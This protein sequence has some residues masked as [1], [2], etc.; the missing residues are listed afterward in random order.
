MQGALCYAGK[1]VMDMIVVSWMYHF[2]ICYFS[3]TREKYSNAFTPHIVAF[4]FFF[5]SSVRH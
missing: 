3:Y 4:F 2:H 1:T 5:L